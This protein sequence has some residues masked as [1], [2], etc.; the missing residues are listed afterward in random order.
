[1]NGEKKKLIEA[2]AL[3][4]V[5]GIILFVTSGEK[6]R[7]FTEPVIL[8]NEPG[9]GK[10]EYVLRAS[11]GEVEIE[12]IGITVNERKYTNK[13]CEEMAKSCRE[14]ILKTLLGSNEDFTNITENLAFEKYVSGYPFEI[15]Y[16]TDT[17]DYISK[18]GEILYPEEFVTKIEIGLTYEDFYDEFCVKAK[19]NPSD[20]VKRG[21]I[22]NELTAKLEV[23]KDVTDTDVL[24]PTEVDGEAVSYVIPGKPRNPAYIAFSGLGCFALLLGNRKDEK[25]KEEK[26]RESILSEYP[27]VL[28]KMSLYLAAGMTIRNTW[29][30]IYEEGKQKKDNPMYEEMGISVNEL[31]SG[32]SEG[33]VY[34][35]FGERTGLSELI[36]FTALLSQNL[37]KGSSKLKELLSEESNSA[38]IKKKQ[39]AV[40]KGEEAGTKLLFP[41]M[42]LLTDA[43]LMIMVPAFWSI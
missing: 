31:Q 16:I 21:I 23:N 39:R 27:V 13:E 2:M 10:K 20:G 3:M 26:R 4:L 34:E 6:E 5:L 30:K 32:I 14:T 19:V 11:V 25:T 9:K 43:L 28:Q 38:F 33:L 29:V 1:M 42:L 24:L 18:N 37:K 8:R 12:D 7:I 36:R 17:P 15:T 40:K 22:K 41:M 35:R